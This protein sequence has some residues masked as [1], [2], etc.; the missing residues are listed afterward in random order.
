MKQPTHRSYAASDVT[1]LGMTM[2][3]LCDNEY[4]EFMLAGAKQAL[5]FLAKLHLKYDVPLD[6]Q[7]NGFYQMDKFKNTD[8][9]LYLQE[10]KIEF[11]ANNMLQFLDRFAEEKRKLELEGFFAEPDVWTWKATDVTGRT[12]PLHDTEVTSYLMRTTLA[13][14]NDFSHHGPMKFELV[15]RNSAR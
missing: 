9:T 4:D 5:L 7:F 15:V 2:A 1:L 10:A 12:R 13:S 14:E 6:A 11:M 3:R 8:M